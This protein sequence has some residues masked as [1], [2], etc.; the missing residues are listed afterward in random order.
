[1]KIPK[2]SLI[3]P[4]GISGSGKSTWINSLPKNEFKLVSPD[5]IRKRVLGSVSDQS[6]SANIF[7]IAY[8]EAAEKL[9]NG[10]TVVFDATNL[11]TK[12]RNILIDKLKEMSGVDF[13]TYYKLFSAN[14]ELSK[15]RI[16]KDLENNVDRSNVPD[17]VIDRQY[18][19]YKNTITNL[20]NMINIDSVSE[21]GVFLSESYKQRIKILSAI[22]K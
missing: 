9:K 10:H 6:Q 4:I 15:K 2:N 12:Y 3:L 11:D 8:K 21:E 13:K 14:P 20:N 16:K 7:D 18:D 22:L 5:L 19:L 17:Y 1:M